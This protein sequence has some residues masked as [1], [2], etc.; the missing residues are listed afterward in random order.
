MRRKAAGVGPLFG[1]R[2]RG[3]SVGELTEEAEGPP[4]QWVQVTA[5]ASGH[6]LLRPVKLFRR[7]LDQEQHRLRDCDLGGKKQRQRKSAELSDWQ[8]FDFLPQSQSQNPCDCL[9]AAPSAPTLCVMHRSIRRRG[10]RQRRRICCALVAS[11]R[12]L[13]F[14]RCRMKIF[15]P[16]CHLRV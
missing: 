1:K 14:F 3:S 8:G 2:V 9:S 10:S 13:L 12:T 15:L 11:R 16:N 5:V 6:R 7:V 4:H